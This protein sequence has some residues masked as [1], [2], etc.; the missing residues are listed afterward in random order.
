MRSMKFTKSLHGIW[1]N[2]VF[3]WDVRPGPKHPFMAN[4]KILKHVD[5]GYFSNVIIDE[6]ITLSIAI[7]FNFISP[8]TNLLS[9]KS[10]ILS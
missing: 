9:L 2:S 6:L 3:R 8:T 5:L 1:K 4:C 10:K 7:Y